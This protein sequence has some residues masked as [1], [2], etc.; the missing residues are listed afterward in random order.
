MSS[1]SGLGN[2]ARSTGWSC[3]AADE[4]AQTLMLETK[5]LRP[6]ESHSACAERRTTRGRQPHVSTTAS[7]ERPRGGAS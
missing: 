6:T 4:S 7:H 5:S 1:R 3:P 2:S